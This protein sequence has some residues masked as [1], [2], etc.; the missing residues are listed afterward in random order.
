MGLTTK[1]TN[2]NRTKQENKKKE[3]KLELERGKNQIRKKIYQK[4]TVTQ[5]RFLF[6]GGVGGGSENKQTKRKINVI[7]WF[8]FEGGNL[9]VNKKLYKV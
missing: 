7:K 8:W 5:L 2:L 3:K 9:T 1:K 4:E 6:G